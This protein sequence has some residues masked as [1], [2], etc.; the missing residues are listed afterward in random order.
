MKAIIKKYK[1]IRKQSF[2][3]KKYTSKYAFIGIGNHSINNLYPVLNYLNVDLKYI[4]SG[5]TETAMS[6]NENFNNTSGTTDL[7]LVLN[8]PEINGVFICANPD[9]HFSLTK[10]VLE[11]GK[12][13]FVEKPPCSN[14]EELKE[15][16]ELEKSSKGF[17]LAGLQ[18][19]Y[20]PVYQILKSK[21]KNTKNYTLKYYTG[22]YPEGNP[23][24]DLFIHPIDIAAY[25]FGEGSLVSVQKTES[26]KGAVNYF[27]HIKHKN[28][29]IGNIE[30]SSDYW[31]AKAHESLLVNTDKLI[32][33]STN[34]D[35]LVCYNK[36]K[37]IL[38]IP[39]EKI[40]TPEISVKT[41]YE[42]NRFLPVASQNELFS[43]GYFNE[44]KTFLNLC[45]NQKS[46]NNS[47]LS[48]LINTF[49]LLSEIK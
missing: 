38:N 36:P 25:L 20:T 40:K 31:W 37:H 9:S 24:M 11:K 42:H 2:L 47:E 3:K 26:G 14:I 8:D 27:L 15:L 12:N 30:L 41:L 48:S 7:D 17:V 43:A 18:K 1:K 22:S 32:Y 16:I 44:L 34:T 23:I 45:E 29:T 21:I 4:V 39:I 6:V 13:V 46:K 33:E 19:R 35:K 10:K 49:D 28:G 5:S